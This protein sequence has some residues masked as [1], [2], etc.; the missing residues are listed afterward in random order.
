MAN[1]KIRHLA[2]LRKLARPTSFYFEKSLLRLRHI[3]SQCLSVQITLATVNA[4]Q[5]CHF[6]RCLLTRFTNN[7][8][9]TC[10]HYARTR[11]GSLFVSMGHYHL[12]LIGIQ[13]NAPTS[14]IAL[15]PLLAPILSYDF[16]AC[17]CT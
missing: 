13:I 15:L 4:I 16:L 10:N 9:M 1:D 8:S 2:W 6:L 3:L 5:G 14:K 7:Y 12:D 17:R 11:K